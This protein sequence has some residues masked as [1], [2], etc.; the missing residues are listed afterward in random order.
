MGLIV[1][2]GGTT[3]LMRKGNVYNEDEW[4][5][6]KDMTTGI[7]FLWHYTLQTALGQR[8]HWI[9][10]G[11]GEGMYYALI[12][13]TFKCRMCISF[14]PCTTSKAWTMKLLRLMRV[15][16]YTKQYNDC[17]YDVMILVY[18]CT[19]VNNEM[20]MGWMT[21]CNMSS[22]PDKMVTNWQYTCWMIK[23]WIRIGLIMATVF[24][25]DTMGTNLWFEVYW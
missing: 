6:R 23:Y 7:T 9:W 12:A 22:E 5:K 25:G 11:T 19:E 16:E 13:W 24:Y 20:N 18:V 3:V 21:Q 17:K 15:Y 8:W 10:N 1:C 2:S 4:M 14:F